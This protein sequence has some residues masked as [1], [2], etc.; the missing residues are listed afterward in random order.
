M[1]NA[2]IRIWVSIPAFAVP[3]GVWSSCAHELGFVAAGT[4]Y[5][6]LDG[7]LAG[8]CSPSTGPCRRGPC[9]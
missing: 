9:P 1:M 5:A 8:R 2:P 7:E 3:A 6:P 4:I